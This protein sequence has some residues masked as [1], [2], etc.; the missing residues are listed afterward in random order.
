MGHP[1]ATR[2]VQLVQAMVARLLVEELGLAG[3]EVALRLGIAPSAV[4]QYVNGRRLGTGLA[5]YASDPALR[6]QLRRLARDI[7]RSTATP[8]E[9]GSQILETALAMGPTPG[10]RGPA[11]EVTLTP[12]LVR[13]LS[14]RI[15]AEQ[16]AVSACMRLAQKARDEYT[17][18]VFR[19]IASDS[20][21][22]A[23]IVASLT[24]ILERGATAAYA[25]GITPDDVRQLIARE[26]H[27]EEG[28]AVQLGDGL[29]GVVALL[30]Q[31]MEADERKHE[32]IL[33]GLLREG[34]R[35]RPARVGRGRAPGAGTRSS[36]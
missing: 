36:R 17:R 19:Q 5:G 25:S 6:H 9:I 33:E 13:Q 16:A 15:A 28:S 27:A 23:E 2:R 26:R 34:F 29:G 8:D 31:S 1:S 18:A 11:E 24:P 20:L 4:S 12:A 22:H 10:A 14:R 3:R 35:A 32:A 21:R 30:L 7:A